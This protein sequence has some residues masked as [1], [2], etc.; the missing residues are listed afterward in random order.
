MFLDSFWSAVAFERHPLR[1]VRRSVRDRD[2]FVL[3]RVEEANPFHADD[4]DCANVQ[5]DITTGGLDLR[6][7]FLDVLDSNAADQLQNHP[8]A[9]CVSV[10]PEC[11]QSNFRATA[12]RGEIK[13]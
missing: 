11:H 7:Q 10:D 2:T 9:E 6:L 3:A 8:F 12:L 1:D 5:N 4:R 13:A